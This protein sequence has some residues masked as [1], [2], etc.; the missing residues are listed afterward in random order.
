MSVTADTPEATGRP[1]GLLHAASDMLDRVVRGAA[2][3]LM[4]ALI[5]VVALQIICRDVLQ[6]AFAGSE[7]LATYVFI[8]LTFLGAGIAFKERSH[9]V[10]TVLTDRLPARAARFVEVFGLTCTVLFLGFLLVRGSSL[11]MAVATQQ[12]QLLQ[13]PM[14]CVYVALPI[15]AAVTLLHLA[16]H[17]WNEQRPRPQDLLP[18]AL[19]IAALGWLMHVD[20]ASHVYVIMVG[21]MIVFM[22]ARIPIAVS[23]GL[24]AV[25]GTRVSSFP[26]ITFLNRM[27]G[28]LNNF[29]LLAVP[30]FLLTGAIMAAGSLA[31]RLVD[32]ANSLVG[33]IRGGLA[34]SNI[35]VSALFAD[36]SG[37]AVA[38]TAAIGSVMM[39]NMIRRGYGVN[40]T[41]ALQASAGSLGMQFPPS[42]SMLLYAWVAGVSTA[43]LFSASLVPACLVAL[44]FAA[45]AYTTARRQRFPKEAR[46]RVALVAHSFRRCV[47]ALV[48]PVIIVG[49]ILGGVFTA[50]E[51]GVVAVLY[52]MLVS[53][54]IYR[55]MP[56]RGMVSILAETASAMGRMMFIIASAVGMSW[57]V[58]VKQG[59]QEFGAA[60]KALSD[61]PLV[62]LLLVNL[63]IIVLGVFLDATAI[64]LVV[65][66]VIL[67]VLVGVGVDPVVFG[68]IFVTSCALGA[69]HPPVGLSLFIAC[70][71][72]GA[73]IEEAS[74]AV[75][76]FMIAKIVDIIVLSVFPGIALLLPHWLGIY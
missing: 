70:G 1:A 15:A 38:D 20:L 3:L 17:I 5:V 59:P 50:T 47:F 74:L 19:A 2:I 66:P 65:V 36:I 30:L 63:L 23:L 41:T 45:V 18:M 12:S 11:T 60:L 76:P 27:I 35:L 33:W 26:D 57:I 69:I 68:V 16:D 9:P 39:P 34:L 8:W 53:L 24:T 31:Q 32:F 43:A 37:S 7:E 73:K 52:S 64:L 40:F 4:S 25:I 29:T 22:L 6:L 49:G 56:L 55:D 28:G 46:F 21:A 67:P 61:D 14:W 75:V 72:S 54:G 44:S 13:I 51:A 48:T 10:L 71:I 58:I 62:I 42:I